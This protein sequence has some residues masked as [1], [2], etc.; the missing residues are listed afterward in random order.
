MNK[1]IKQRFILMKWIKECT[2]W[3]NEWTN[4]I[5]IWNK[6]INTETWATKLFTVCAIKVY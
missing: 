2:E 1:L 3:M 6:I 4:E 5:L